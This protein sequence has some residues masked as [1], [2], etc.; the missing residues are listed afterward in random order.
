MNLRKGGSEKREGIL[1]QFS[2]FFINKN[3]TYTHTCITDGY[4]AVS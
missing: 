3:S 1:L 2:L 4:I